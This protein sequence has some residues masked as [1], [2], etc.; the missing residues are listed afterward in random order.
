MM[1]KQKLDNDELGYVRDIR[2]SISF[3]EDIRTM[4][5]SFKTLISLGVDDPGPPRNR[6]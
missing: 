2:N 3:K 6:L 5:V 4:Q 1:K